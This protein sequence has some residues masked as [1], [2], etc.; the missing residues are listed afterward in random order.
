MNKKETPVEV[1]IV[2]RPVD[3]W[4]VAILITQ[5]II[6]GLTAFIALSIGNTQNAIDQNIL[7]ENSEPS[8]S[9]SFQS[10]L[11][12][13]TNNGKTNITVYTATVGEPGF[14]SSTYAE[15][16]IIDAG[17]SDTISPSSQD[18]LAYPGVASAIEQALSIKNI[19]ELLPVYIYFKTDNGEKYIMEFVVYFESVPSGTLMEWGNLQYLQFNWREKSDQ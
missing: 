6:L 4:G 12:I 10:P 9:T 16:Q 1:E 14:S 19:N 5:T 18:K 17:S 11:I 2:K 3:R 8:L 13:I 7:N 15:S